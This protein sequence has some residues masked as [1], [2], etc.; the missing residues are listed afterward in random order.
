MWL[1]I[2]RSRNK[3]QDTTHKRYLERV[4]LEGGGG[5]KGSSLNIKGRDEKGKVGEKGERGKG[6]ARIVLLSRYGW[7][8][9]YH[10][11]FYCSAYIQ[12]V[13]Y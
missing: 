2:Y 7:C 13:S 11:N 8:K 10:S 6:K 12:V 5:C 4:R 3:F 9:L 1:R